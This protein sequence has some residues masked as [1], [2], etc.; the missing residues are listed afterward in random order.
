ME[1]W[2]RDFN[3]KR[4]LKQ[5]SLGYHKAL[6]KV[7]KVPWSVSNHQVCEANILLTF[8]GFKRYKI[9][10]FVHRIFNDK[11][12]FM[13]NCFNFLL[14]SSVILNEVDY[15]MRS[16]YNVSNFLDNDIDALYTFSILAA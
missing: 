9:L 13:I 8:D 5:C 11:P 4:E 2:A 3:C 10:R 1:L 14:S 6:K 16:I 7:L 15:F 12:F